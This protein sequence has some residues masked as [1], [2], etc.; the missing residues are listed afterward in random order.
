MSTVGGVT[1]VTH[2]S[3]SF[4][5]SKVTGAVLTPKC[6]SCGGDGRLLLSQRYKRT[7]AVAAMFHTDA[8]LPHRLIRTRQH[9]HRLLCVVYVDANEPVLQPDA[10]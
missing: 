9:L 5:V 7:A 3:V 8:V 2:A 6:V 10:V 1:T 4:V